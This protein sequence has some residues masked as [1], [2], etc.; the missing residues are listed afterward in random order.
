MGKDARRVG[1]NR[2]GRGKGHDWFNQGSQ[3]LFSGK[4]IVRPSA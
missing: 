2:L 1:V 3:P 4:G